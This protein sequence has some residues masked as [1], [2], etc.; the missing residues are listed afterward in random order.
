M[1]SHDTCLKKDCE[2]SAES[3]LELAII[4]VYRKGEGLICAM[5]VCMRGLECC[6][7]KEGE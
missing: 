5:C 4:Q 2:V 1:E 7:K 3:D 6:E